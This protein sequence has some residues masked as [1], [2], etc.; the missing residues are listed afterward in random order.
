ML[1]KAT[2][3]A[4]RGLIYIQIQNWNAKRPGVP[5]IAK[6]IEAPQ[7][8]TA[9]ILHTLTRQGLL[10]SMKGRGGG[11]FFENNVSDLTLYR[12]ILVMEGDGLFTKCG[13]GLKNCS[14]RNP[15]PIHEE[16]LSIRES[17]L[18]LARTQTISS[19]AEK[20]RGGKAVLSRVPLLNNEETT[21]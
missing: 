9:K 6:E 16:F 7:P 18:E 1:S 10:L 12:V 4:L 20:V 8:F 14:D 21:P 19:L 17:L 2:E 11:F 5:G 13:F 15:C 3:Y